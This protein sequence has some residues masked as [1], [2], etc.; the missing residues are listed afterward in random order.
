MRTNGDI[1]KIRRALVEIRGRLEAVERAIDR[2][3]APSP[4]PPVPAVPAPPAVPH[5]AP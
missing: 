5:Q 1:E 2:L 3:S 4:V